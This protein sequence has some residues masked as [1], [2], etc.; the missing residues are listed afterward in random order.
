MFEKGT[1]LI[2][3]ICEV[4]GVRGIKTLDYIISSLWAI[5]YMSQQ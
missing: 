3:F 2:G 4:S 1:I 5:L